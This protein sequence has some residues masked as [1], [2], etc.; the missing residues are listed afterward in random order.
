MKM[1]DF[2]FSEV[3]NL[4]IFGIGDTY[5][6]SSRSQVIVAKLPFLRSKGQRLRLLV[7]SLDNEVRLLRRLY[8]ETSRL[9]RFALSLSGKV[10][11]FQ[12]ER[13]RKVLKSRNSQS[14][15]FLQD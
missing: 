15:A 12:L 4:H 6:V 7:S 10:I 3:E 9:L 8:E 5:F 14:S 1:R 13:E 2:Q 11:L